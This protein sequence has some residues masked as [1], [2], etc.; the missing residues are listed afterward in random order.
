MKVVVDS[1]GGCFQP[2]PLA[3]MRYAELK[4]L[5]L[6]IYWRDLR[7]EHYSRL[8]NIEDLPANTYFSDILYSLR[9][10]GESCF[11]EEYKNLKKDEKWDFCF[12]SPISRDDSDLVHVIEELGSKKASLRGYLQAVEIPDGTEWEILTTGDC[13]FEFIVE[14]GHHWGYKLCGWYYDR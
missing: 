9:D 7:S 6:Y 13:D 2:S 8:V 4:G 11:S 3:L 10:L 1:G 12:D 14:K 5:T